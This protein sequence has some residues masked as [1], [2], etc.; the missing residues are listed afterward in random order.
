MISTLVGNVKI[1]A[2]SGLPRSG[3]DTM[4]DELVRNYGYTKFS[5]AEPIYKMLNTLPFLEHIHSQMSGEEKETPKAFY[6]KS[7]RDM[8]RTL[9][10]EWARNHVSPDVWIWILQYKLEKK[11]DIL[12]QG[13]YVITDLRF[14]NEAVWVRKMGGQIVRILRGHSLQA[15]DHV[16]DAG[17]PMLI[18]DATIGNDGTLEEFLRRAAEVDSMAENA[19]ESARS[20]AAQ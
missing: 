10:T 7:P 5:F 2:L 16:S 6:G 20:R 9:G 1:V 4:A 14:P 8:L 19:R 17:F 11:Y 13:N 15:S 3:K 12:R 18:S